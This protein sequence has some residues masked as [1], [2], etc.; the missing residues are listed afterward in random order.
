VWRS[1]FVM[2]LASASMS[3][4]AIDIHASAEAQQEYQY[5]QVVQTE[6]PVAERPSF[7]CGGWLQLLGLVGYG[8]IPG[9]LVQ[10]V[11][12][13][14]NRTSEKWFIR[15]FLPGG[16]IFHTLGLVAPIELETID[17]HTLQGMG[18]VS[19]GAPPMGGKFL[20]GFGFI[21]YEQGRNPVGVHTLHSLTPQ[22][23]LGFFALSFSNQLSA[24]SGVVRTVERG[25]SLFIRD[26]L[27]LDSERLVER[28]GRA[29]ADISRFS[30]AERLVLR[31]PEALR[32]DER[33]LRGD[34][35][36]ELGHMEALPDRLLFDVFVVIHGQEVPFGKIRLKDPLAFPF[37]ASRY[38]NYRFHVP[39]MTRRR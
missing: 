19:L 25:L 11:D 3:Q 15:R 13:F 31:A 7:S 24:D 10:V 28:A 39:H 14:T 8:V 18:R 22:S 16:N 30:G 35:V 5:R 26:P 34:W 9:G 23:E 4:A 17:G 32:N 6:Y 21:L 38:G 12:T 1:L 33:F 2:L 36:E 20:P 37:L 27:H 29:G